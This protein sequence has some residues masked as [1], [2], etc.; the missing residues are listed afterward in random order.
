MP[1]GDTLHNL[2]ARLDA[3][4]TGRPIHAVIAR[5]ASLEVGLMG[6]C[7]VATGAVGKNLLLRLS[8]GTVLRIHLGMQGEW[9]TVARDRAAAALDPM[10]SLRVDTD[11][12]RHTL[13]RA[14]HL[15]RLRLSDLA[16]H[17]SLSRLGP[18]L[19]LPQVD[20]D[21]VLK[22]GQHVTLTVSRRGQTVAVVARRLSPMLDSL[23]AA[24]RAA[25]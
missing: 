14:K 23:A 8:D 24:G 4:L 22:S 15:E 20:L 17:P 16:R 19:C 11:E 6:A 9:R 5:D 25:A 18:D 10:L 13:L 12:H 3:L 7:V 1:E 2:A 21:V